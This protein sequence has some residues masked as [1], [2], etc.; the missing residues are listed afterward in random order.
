VSSS[1]KIFVDIGVH[2]YKGIEIEVAGAEKDVVISTINDL[3]NDYASKQHR[4]YCC[5]P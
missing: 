3:T 4:P 5:A 1:S 2:L